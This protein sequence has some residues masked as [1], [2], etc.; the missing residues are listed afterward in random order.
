MNPAGDSPLY[1]IQLPKEA[2]AMDHNDPSNSAVKPGFSTSEGKIALLVVIVTALG[3]IVAMLAE[4]F[5]EDPR[6]Q[7]V[8]VIVASIT[9]VLTT[10]GYTKSRDG[11]KDTANA[12]AVAL[13]LAD[14]A[15][16]AAKENPELAR[17]L[18]K[19]AGVSVPTP[20]ASS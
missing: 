6:V 1:L 10:L 18:L 11:R 9:L 16:A 4:K 7:M 14:K 8:V 13:A 12:G 2:A 20:P 5:P 15:I 19:S 3:P 17:N